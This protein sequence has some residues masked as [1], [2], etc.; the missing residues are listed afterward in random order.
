MAD[1]TFKKFLDQDAFKQLVTEIKTADNAVLDAAKAHCDAKDKLFDATGSA[2]KALEDAN[3]YTDEK[4]APL[5]TKVSVEEVDGKVTTEKERAMAEESRIAGLVDATTAVANK[6]A[7]DI[8]A[9]AE[10]HATDKGALE[11]KDAELAEDI[12]EL[13]ELVGE[14]PEGT[15][16]TTVIEYVNKKTEGIATDAALGELQSAV[17]TIEGEVA[18]IKADYLKAADKTEL[19]GKITAESEAARAAEKANADAIK[20]ISDDYLT[21][22]DKEA[23]QGSI[24]GVSAVANAAVKQ[25][26][27]DVKVKALE[28]EDAR[29]AGLVASEAEAARAAEKANAD[30]I[31]AIKED[32]DAFFKDA[33]M[34]ETAKETLKDIQGYITEHTAEA[35]EMTAAIQKNK[36]D[37]AANKKSIDD[38]LATDHDFAGADAALKSELE[39]KI[40]GKVAQGDFD[41]VEGRV[42]TLEGE[43]DTVEGKVSTLEGQMTT[44]QG[45]VAT[46]VEQ[47]AYNAKVAE[48]AGADEAQVERIAALEAKFGD[49]EGNVESQIEAAKQAAISAAAADATSKA[50]TAESNAK[51]HANNLDSAMNTRVAKLEA[52]SATHALA[53][54]LTTLAGRVTTAEGEIDTLQGEMDAVEAKA[55]ANE[56]AIATINTELA[57]KALQSD[58]EATNA[59]VTANEGAIATKAS[60]DDLDDAVERVAQNEANIVT[61][62]AGIAANAAAIAAF[63]PYTA[64]E[65]TALW[66]S[67]TV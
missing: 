48:L 19:E 4:V 21:S 51:T 52:D 43:M 25:A 53:S 60:Q 58:L 66:N 3:K 46:K 67:V 30:A 26:D 9:L 1:S 8:A 14:L 54:D 59:K 37:I 10:T 16:A 50:N 18:G 49:G 47:E 29:I 39:G 11:A 7:T 2:A 31:A 33:D 17:G 35:G 27:Y 20:A 40:N 56:G 65:V 23:L 42:D 5:A 34:A 38:H 44:V 15:E 63:S 64:S 28:D 36:E 13:A 6:A 12:A 55:A 57:K 61:A 22:E 24:N 41:V 62:N 45:A 32:V